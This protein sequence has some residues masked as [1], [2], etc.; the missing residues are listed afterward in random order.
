[1]RGPRPSVLLAVFALL[2]A[3][4]VRPAHGQILSLPSS[5]PEPDSWIAGSAVFTNA[6]GLRDDDRGSYWTVQGVS[7]YR[8]SIDKS[9]SPGTTVGVAVTFTNPAIAVRG[10]TLCA[11]GCNATGQFVSYALTYRTSQYTPGLS[12]VGELSAGVLRPGNLRERT[13]GGAIAPDRTIPFLALGGGVA[14]TTSKRWQVELVQEY[15]SIFAGGG[16]G[17]AATQWV[18]RLGLRIGFGSRDGI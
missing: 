1:M 10:G 4:T 13:T 17:G 9:L 6:M 15:S 16:L 2:S 7:G 5:N 8:V 12:S 14:F 3:V 11:T 18:T